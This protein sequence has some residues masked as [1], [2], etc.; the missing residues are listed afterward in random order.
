MNRLSLDAINRLSED[1]TQQST[2][3]RHPPIDMSRPFVP[4]ENTQLPYTPI[5]ASLTHEQKLRYNQ[6]FG[7][8]INEYIMMLERDL[9]ER[10]VPALFRRDELKRDPQLCFALQTMLTEERKH[11]EGFAA[12]NRKCRP[13]LYSVEK[14]RHFSRLPAWTSAMFEISGWLTPYFPFTLWYLMAVEESAKSLARDLVRKKSGSALGELD[15]GFVTLHHEHLRDETRHI[16]IDSILIERCLDVKRAGIN[17]WLFEAMLTGVTTPTR[18]GSG[19]KV[20]RQLVIDMPEL[21]PREQ[22]LIDSLIALKD[23]HEFQ[24]SLFNRRIV[25]ESFAVFDRF[26]ALANLD[27]KLKGYDRRT[28]A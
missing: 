20:I 11:Y 17:A 16:H 26:P 19:A 2:M 23:H 8:R 7:L 9:M 24:A 6:L 10:L 1:E 5:Y 27:R 18:S 15:E 21:A 22:A 14:D 4:E 3:D 13:D 28:V 25:P 12:F